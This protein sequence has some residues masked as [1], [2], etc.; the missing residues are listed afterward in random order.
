MYDEAEYIYQQFQTNFAEQKN[1]PFILYGIG[2]NTG[3]LLPK[4]A[5]YNIV[6]LMDGKRKDG[7]IWEKKILDYDEVKKSGVKD[8]III[9]RPAVIGVIY[10]R[11]SEFCK[12]NHIIVYDVNGRDLSQ[13]Y[14]N[15]E[16]DI[17]YFHLCYEDLKGEV[18]KHSIISFDIFDTL[19]MRKT[20]YPKD[21]FY[22][23]EK[24]I[25]EAIS[26]S[27]ASLRISAEEELYKEGENPT[28]YDIYERIQKSTEISDAQKE[29][30]LNLELNTEL[31]FLIPRKKMLELF[32][33]IKEKKKIYLIS[34]MYLTKDILMKIL[35]K[36]GYE[37]YEDIFVSCEEGS[38][39]NE[40]LFDIFREKVKGAEHGLHIGDNHIADIMSARKSGLDTFQ[41]MSAQ[42]LLE[43]S[44][45]KKLLAADTGLM[46]HLAIGLFCEKAFNDP[47]ILYNS[48]GKLNVKNDNEFV[49]LFI[50]PMIF[51]FVIWLI[52]K[53]RQ[54]GCD[55]VLYTS[56][57]SFLIQ[58]ICQMIIE[59]QRIH[60]FP[61]GV[62]FYT[63]RRSVSAATIWNETDIKTR[64][65]I[66]FW[67]DIRE[68]FKR[69][70]DIEIEEQGK[71]VR[72][73]D[74]SEIEFLIKKY[75]K[76]ILEQS[77]R[78]RK[79][80]IS[81]ILKTG[82]NQY[83][84]IALIDFV[85]VG[86]VQNGLEKL[87]SGKEIQGFYFLKRQPGKKELDRDVKV[88]SFYPS[89]GDFEI[90][91]NIYH[92]YLFL[93]LVLTSP[94]PTFHSVGDDG[95][96]RFM[97]ETRSKEH[98]KVIERLQDS[99]ID[100]ANEFVRLYPDLEKEKINKEI[101]DIILGFL[102]KE[103]TILDIP[104][105]TR[106]TLADE[107]FSQTFNILE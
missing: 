100:Y 75:E 52:Q 28:I 11:I 56:R 14:A 17:P 2:N 48:K 4:I 74:N 51:Y 62:Y 93:E 104:E 72:V 27:F 7:I 102:G 24:K 60:N 66:D 84:R 39:K 47:F 36:C 18:E 33:D 94:E 23:V 16:N 67:G 44:S 57:D 68:M 22:I 43:S 58:K 1:K 54:M 30:I 78:E 92:Y 88:E 50:A 6:G 106:L 38:S 77:E 105:I 59:K 20:L 87:I 95:K 19:I 81:Y 26:F 90:D 8:I 53:I 32:N 79:N 40:G 71:D 80:Y 89:K 91:S 34:D 70:F 15:Q 41:V 10:H 73:M 31:E 46:D 69:R 25:D 86:T 3:K 37:G 101:P 9:A 96:M 42:E 49:Y 64:T 98:C 85:A 55:F 63:S 103:Y 35:N 65:R 99:I 13:V 107:F 82:I 45:Y 12:E 29:Q 97:D 83:K 61:D 21:I 5:D 76:E